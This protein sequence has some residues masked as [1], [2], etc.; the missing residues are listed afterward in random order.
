MSIAVDLVKEAGPYV[1]G[2]AGMYATYRSGS[3]QDRDARH[4]A[5]VETLYL[6][7][8]NAYNYQLRMYIRFLSDEDPSQTEGTSP[9]ELADRI[10]L[11]AHPKVQSAWH[12]AL[13]RLG[14]RASAAD[15]TPGVNTHLHSADLWLIYQERLEALATEMRTDLGIPQHGSCRLPG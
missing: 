9:A 6:E 11:F 2:L 5:R 14:E 12:M 13:K 8:R 4:N 10:E 7:M 1:L 3:R 15:D